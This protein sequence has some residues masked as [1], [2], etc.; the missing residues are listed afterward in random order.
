M[1]VHRRLA[2]T[3]LATAAALLALLPAGAVQAQ[4]LSLANVHGTSLACLFSPSCSIVVHDTSAPVVLPGT[5]GSGF[6]QS[7]TADPAPAGTAAAGLIP[8]MW[9]LDLTGLSG[10]RSPCVR[11]VAIV[12]GDIAPLNYDLDRVLEDVFVVTA[13]GIGT[14]GPTSASLAPWLTWEL[15]TPGLCAGESSFFFGL[16]SAAAPRVTRAYLE[17]TNNTLLQVEVRAPAP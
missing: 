4:S 13:G 11:R 8:Y 1:T 10:L 16:A 9:R 14:E 7:R 6:L 5:T 15:G 12:T 17:L 3:L 2:T